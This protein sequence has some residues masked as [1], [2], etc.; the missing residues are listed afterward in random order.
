MLLLFVSILVL[1]L[2]IILMIINS[3]TYNE[4]FSWFGIVAIVIGS[5]IAFISVLGVIDS[6]S[7]QDAKLSAKIA[8]R[9]AIVWQ[10]ENNQYDGS[11]NAL[12]KF[13]AE[14]IENKMDLENP[15]FNWMTD[16]YYADIEP[17]DVSEYTTVK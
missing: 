1:A 4:V 17:I 15:W 5:L 10:I 2:G 8:E 3:K 12:G 16:Q 11:S 7:R 14:V 6:H 13:N 9:E